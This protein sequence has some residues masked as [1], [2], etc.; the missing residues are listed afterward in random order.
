MKI[1]ML[2]AYPFGGTRGI[3]GIYSIVYFLSLIGIAS[4]SSGSIFR[5]LIGIRG[6][7]ARGLIF[8]LPIFIYFA[9]ITAKMVS[10]GL[11]MYALYAAILFCI[12]AIPAASGRASVFLDKAKGGIVKF[13]SNERLFLITI[14]L[15]AFLIRYF[16]GLRLLEL[17][18]ANFILASDDGPG[19][20]QYASTIAGGGLM[21]KSAVYGVSGF[22]YWYF[23]AG[24]YRI[25]GLHNFK[26]MIAAQSFIGAFVPMFTY[27]IGR[28]IFKARS[29]PVL[30]AIIASVDMTLVFLSVVIGMEAIYIPLV[31]LALAV[32]AH[33]LSRKTVEIKGAL[34]L[35]CV[36]GLAY[37]ARP[38]ELLL[39]PAALGLIIFVKNRLNIRRSMPQITALFVGFLLLVSV[40]FATN[41]LIYDQP[42]SLPGAVKASFHARGGAEENRILGEM[43][44]VPFEDLK[45]SASVFMQDP[46]GVSK[47]ISKGF[48]K[49]LFILYLFPNFGVF[50]PVF[51]VNPASGYFFR[52]PV[53][54]QLCGYLLVAAGLAAAFIR[55]E[56]PAGVVTV[57]AF[58]AYI[59]VRVALFFVFNSRYRGVLMPIFIL[60]FS[61][62]AASF[63]SIVKDRYTR[64]ELEYGS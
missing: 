25:F 31:F 29:A 63:Y 7:A 61:Y 9:Y 47:L 59:S 52:F 12:P 28:K 44:F 8:H 56:N 53:F 11:I 34:L 50:D 16:W 17:T 41:Y 57:F 18:G 21:Q 22:G 49:R 30:A 46:A 14:F 40:Q 43:G 1:G 27:F 13:V 38:P 32:A 15:A 39:F 58:L 24:I 33:V 26:V 5:R 10:G 60:F 37:L 35:G 2:K 42:P 55:K 4:Y 23:L 62:G 36:F 19:Y 51:L 48:F 3:Y 64:R 45:G 6:P 20:D 54:A